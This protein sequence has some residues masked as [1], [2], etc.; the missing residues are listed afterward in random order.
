MGYKGVQMKT[1][2]TTLNILLNIVIA[3]LLKLR[4]V[5]EATQLMPLIFIGITLYLGAF[6]NKQNSQ[7]W[8]N[9]MYLNIMAL[10][11]NVVVI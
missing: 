5:P 8:E 3:L 10:G 7:F 2:I 1:A 4:L 11:Y 9:L 6:K